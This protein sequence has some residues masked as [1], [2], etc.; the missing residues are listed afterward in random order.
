MIFEQRE[1]LREVFVVHHMHAAPGSCH[2][3]LQEQGGCLIFC[4][5]RRQCETHA[6]ALVTA[7]TKAQQMPGDAVCT[8]RLQLAM[9]LMAVQGGEM[10]APL[11]DILLSCAGVAYHHAGVLGRSVSGCSAPINTVAV[12]PASLLLAGH[13]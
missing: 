13:G 1:L 9:D 3:R 7:V 5:M 11:R 2:D 8:A 4:T 10:L 6:L 12:W